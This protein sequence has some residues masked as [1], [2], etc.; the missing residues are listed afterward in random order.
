MWCVQ[1]SEG[2]SPGND[3]NEDWENDAEDVAKNEAAGAI[4]TK[5]RGF[6]SRKSKLLRTEEENTGNQ[7]EQSK[8]LN[9]NKR[10]ILNLKSL[11]SS[12]QEES[13]SGSRGTMRSIIKASGVCRSESGASRRKRPTVA[14]SSKPIGKNRFTI[15]R[16]AEDNENLGKK[17]L[18][19]VTI[20]TKKETTMIV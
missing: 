1:K 12:Q 16:A 13:S 17:M 3:G 20:L 18:K 19:T 14:Q 10:A 4:T 15:Q 2:P 5:N 9:K 6:G 7:A 8:Q 11:S